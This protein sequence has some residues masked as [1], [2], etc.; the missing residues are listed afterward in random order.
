[1]NNWFLYIIFTAIFIFLF[2]YKIYY[3]LINT[4]KQNKKVC[5]QN[6]LYDINNG[7]D[8]SYYRID[9]FRCGYNITYNKNSYI[10]NI[11]ETEMK[12]KNDRYVHE[13]YKNKL[14]YNKAC[15]GVGIDY[16]KQ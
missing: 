11:I 6:L 8:F 13:I 2:N 12:N 3:T 14:F 7:T 9:D 15:C 4:T 10:R 5:L 16:L 1:M